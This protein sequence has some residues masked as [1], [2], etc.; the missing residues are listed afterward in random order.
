M[1]YK[2]QTLGDIDRRNQA[3]LPL[4]GA[5]EALRRNLF[6]PLAR[7][8]S[9]AEFSLQAYATW[10]W[11]QQFPRLCDDDILESIHVPMRLKVGR[12]AAQSAVGY[13]LIKGA[14]GLTVAEAETATRNDGVEYVLPDGAIIGSNGTVTAR[15][16]CTT[17]G[18]NGNTEPA[19]KLTLAN[20]ISGIETE[21]EIIGDGLTGGAD[22]ESI[23]ALR[24]RCEAAWRNPGD[25]G[26]S[27]DYEQWAMEVAGVTRAWAAPKVLGVG[28]M[29]VYFVRD[30]DKDAQGNPA[31]YPS[32][33]ECATVTHHLEQ[34]ALPF[35]EI[36]A[37]APV[38][39][40]QNFRIR[41]LPDTPTIRAAVTSALQILIAERAAP[42]ARDD[43]G[44]TVM[45]ITG[46]TIP[47]THFAQVISEALGEYNHQ[48]V[49]PSA[50]VVC[51]VGE[52]L[53]FGGVA[54]L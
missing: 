22:I 26:T 5:S 46:V 9:G 38:P 33:S 2:L 53:E 34:T 8:L 24:D 11:R 41:L 20:P 13:V 10:V 36:Y 37:L 17:H 50:D 48:L 47:L 23:D 44:I 30:L 35:G 21:L 29:S 16:V 3:E 40:V 1:P 27:T 45:P 54:W 51:A 31:I 18:Q 42:V 52:M 4:S 25:V 28:T 14:E 49:E 15:V 6:T 32:E 12:K 7:A 39:K 19:A 43:Y